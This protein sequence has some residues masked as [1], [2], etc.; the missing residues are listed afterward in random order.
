MK[1]LVVKMSSMGDVVHALPA[2]VEARRAVPDIEFHW[3]V[4][5]GFQCIPEGHPQVDEVIPVAIR[6]WRKNWLASLQSGEIAEF[7]RLLR[8]NRYDL[9]IDGQGLIKSAIVGRLARGPVSGFSWL[10]A[11]EPLASLTYGRSVNVKKN[12]HAVDR[13]RQLFAQLFGY[14]P[15]GPVDYGMQL[16]TVDSPRSKTIIFLH[17]TSWVS[18]LWPITYW[19]SLSLMALEEGYEV[20]IPS[21]DE[22]E[23]RRAD[24][25]AADT[26]ATRLPSTPLA[27]LISIMKACSA[28]VSVDTGLGHVACAQG[29]PLVAICGATDPTL[30]GIRGDQQEVIVGDHLPCIPCRKRICKYPAEVDSSKIYPPCVEQITPEAVWQALQSQIPKANPV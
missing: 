20:L 11:R 10:S 21:A 14:E 17:G 18:K 22:E 8:A 23:S 27:K 5:E 30:T 24:A 16:A 28:A 15:V 4:E 12:L 1:V 29:I 19:R 25:I 3:V 6:R 26:G 2:I 9:I 13:Q 7:Y